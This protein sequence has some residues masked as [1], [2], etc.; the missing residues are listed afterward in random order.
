MVTTGRRW[1][2]GVPQAATVGW[3]LA[4]DSARRNQDAEWQA[5]EAPCQSQPPGETAPKPLDCPMTKATSENPPHPNT[6]TTLSLQS[7]AEC[8]GEPEGKRAGDGN[9]SHGEGLGGTRVKASTPEPGR[10]TN[11]FFGLMINQGKQPPGCSRSDFY[12]MW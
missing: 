3:D 7:S 11:A 2:P 4:G 10:E 12:Q 1:R 9:S 8:A 6:H 5:W